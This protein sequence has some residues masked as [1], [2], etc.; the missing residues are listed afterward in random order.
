MYLDCR[1]FIIVQYYM[2]I[3]PLVNFKRRYFGT[4]FIESAYHCVF[5]LTH[6]VYLYF[7]LQKQRTLY[8]WNF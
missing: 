5:S 2:V 1:D 8:R 7:R 3:Y 4:F 6:V